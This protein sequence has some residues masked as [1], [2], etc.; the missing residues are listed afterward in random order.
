MKTKCNGVV[1][2]KM[3]LKWLPSY[4]NYKRQQEDVKN[5]KLNEQTDLKAATNQEKVQ[6]KSKLRTNK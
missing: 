4:K 6:L 2:K 5:N 1:D 3:Y